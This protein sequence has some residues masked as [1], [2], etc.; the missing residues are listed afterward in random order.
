MSS[1]ERGDLMPRRAI[2]GW[3]RATLL[4]LGQLDLMLSRHWLL[5]LNLLTGFFIAL[6]VAAPLLMALG[7]T[8]PGRVLYFVNGLTCHQLPQR[9]YFLF[10][11]GLFQTYSWDEL[12][13]Q[14][15]NPAWPK[16]FLG[17]PVLGYKM[18]LAHRNVAIYA[19]IFVG[20]LVYGLARWLVRRR[21]PALLPAWYAVFVVPMILDGISHL[22][23]EVSGLGFRQ[24]NEWLRWL[25]GGLLSPSFYVGEGLGSFNWLMRT[26]TGALFSLA[27]IWVAYPR[28]ESA[29]YD[30]ERR[31]REELLTFAM[32]SG[33]AEERGHASQ[34]ET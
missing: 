9:S 34:I 26:L 32:L 8:A 3:L 13:A 5:I 30:A 20:G 2:K 12:L 17:S 7:L 25:S 28:V 10:G 1:V 27:T 16:G 31:A 4:W 33:L 18:A 23:S 15:M 6:A 29:F 11:P 22:V 14:G 21:V 24:A 19:S